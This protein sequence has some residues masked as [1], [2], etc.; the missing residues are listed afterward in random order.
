MEVNKIVESIKV[1]LLPE[2]AQIR[3]EIDQVYRE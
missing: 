3:L 2:F 1:I